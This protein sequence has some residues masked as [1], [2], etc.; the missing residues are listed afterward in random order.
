MIYEVHVMLVEP[1]SAVRETLN[2]WLVEEGYNVTALESGE[3][4]VKL[5]CERPWDIVVLSFSLPGISGMEVLER[6]AKEQP[7]MPV[8]TLMESS[9]MNMTSEAVKA[10][11]AD[12][13]TKP[14][15]QAEVLVTVRRIVECRVCAKESE[16][17][18]RRLDGIFILYPTVGQSEAI[19][20]IKEKIKT[21]GVTDEPV[22][23]LGEPGT[24]KEHLAKAIHAQSPRRYMP[25]ETASLGSIPEALIESELFGHEKAAFTGAAFIKKGRFELAAFGTIYLDEVAGLGIGVQEKIERVLDGKEFRR[26]DGTQAIKSNVRV[27]ASSRL[28]VGELVKAGTFREDLNRRFNVTTFYVP[29]LRERPEDISLLADHFLQIFSARINKRIK[30]ISQR[31]LDFLTEYSWPGNVRELQNAIER[32]VILVRNDRVDADDLPF[33][34]RGY[35][36]APRTKSV[37]EWEKYHIRRVLDENNWNISKSAKDLGIDRV[38]LYNKIKKYKLKKPGAEEEGEE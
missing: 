4:A 15:D 35:L 29:S 2:T 34:I 16:L 6:M 31:A 30:R 23:I 13:I 27:I 20:E 24:G 19:V 14:L 1:D 10:G 3:S 21:V 22:M 17:L 33:S 28:D 9:Q 26:V 25:F 5:I 8:L 32:A 12:Y 36:E 7:G 37:K 38:T 11:A 18:R